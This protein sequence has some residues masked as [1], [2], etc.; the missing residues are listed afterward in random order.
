MALSNTVLNP[1]VEATPFLYMGKW[2]SI[3]F[4]YSS[5]QRDP[6]WSSESLRSVSES[7]NSET[8]SI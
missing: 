3:F 1:R 8:S 2:S 7:R 6:S 5:F 4:L